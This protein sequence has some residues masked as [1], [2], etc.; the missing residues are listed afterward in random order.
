MNTQ[1]LVKGLHHV[2]ATVGDAQEDYQFYTHTLGLRLVKKTVNFDNHHVYHF[3]YGNEAGTPGTIMTTFPYKGQNV[4]QGV[5]GSG[6]VAITSFSSP[7]SALG[8]WQDRLTEAGTDVQEGEKFGDRF[9]QFKDPAGLVLEIVAND[10]DDRPPWITDEINEKVAIRGLFGVTLSIAEAPPTFDFLTDIFGFENMGREGSITRFAASG[11]GPG[12][13][14]DVRHDYHLHQGKNGIGTVHH[15][16]WRVENDEAL[17]AMRHHL[18]G[19][20][21]LK[22]TDFKDRKYFHS[23]YFRIPGGVLFEIATIPPGFSIDEPLEKL[24]QELKLP[25]WE[26]PNREQL[27]R[28]LPEIKPI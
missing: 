28:I 17:K 23:I 18:A 8:F 6:Q 9:L 15:V 24:G 27:E 26:E 10:Q 25:E 1:T 14:V 22:V 12:K 7:E 19:E 2:T 13:L 20:L 3:Y 4:R 16:A 5:H 11:G 21:G